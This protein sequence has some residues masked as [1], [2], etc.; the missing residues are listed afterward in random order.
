MTENKNYIFH[1][2]R[3]LAGYPSGIYNISGGIGRLVDKEGELESKIEN[4]VGGGGDSVY[5]WL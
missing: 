2:S 3:S 1:L 4:K 5:R